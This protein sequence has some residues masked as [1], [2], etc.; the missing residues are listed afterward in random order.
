MLLKGFTRIV[1]VVGPVLLLLC[2]F[3]V[4]AFRDAISLPGWPILRSMNGTRP[5]TEAQTRSHQQGSLSLLKE[6]DRKLAETHVQLFSSATKTGKYF[7]IDFGSR[8]AS[9]P[10]IIPHPSLDDTWIIIAVQEKSSLKGS[11]WFAEL[12]CNAVFEDDKLVCVDPPLI[13]PVA[14]TMGDNLKCTGD[15]FFFATNVG[16]HDARVFYGPKEP[17]TIYGSNS[18]FTCFGMWMQDFRLLTDWGHEPYVES[19]F[20]QATELQ[21]PE[22]WQLVEKNWFIFWDIEG[23]MYA[24]YDIAPKRVFA[25]LQFDGSAGPDLAPNAALLDDQCMERHMPGVGPDL[26][27]LHQA[28]NSLSV[29]LCRRSDTS[30]QPDGSNTFIFTIFQHKTFYAFHS[31]YEPYVMLFNQQAPFQIHAISRKPLWIHGRGRPGEVIPYAMSDKDAREWDQTEMFYV[32][33]ISW[34]T[35]GKRYHGY[36]D[37]PLFIAFGI[38]DTSSGG[39]EILAGDLMAE[40]GLCGAP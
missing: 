19:K 33:S 24:H 1:V 21:R 8:K 39:M 7:P 25:E 18:R 11:V 29:T 3:A 40:L 6:F 28:T 13:M 26:E 5:V 17:Y 12:V 20:R 15:L 38:E 30:C 2:L 22:P 9:N 34:K 4:S 10:N 14:A 35:H 36:I 37:D 16:P 32:T 27:S 31:V 23:K